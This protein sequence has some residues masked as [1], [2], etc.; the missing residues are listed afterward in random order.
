MENSVAEKQSYL[1][2]QPKEAKMYIFCDG[3]M[4]KS[5]TLV[6]SCYAKQAIFLTKELESYTLQRKLVSSAFILK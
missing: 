1:T 4:L 5:K 3:E 2:K 6:H